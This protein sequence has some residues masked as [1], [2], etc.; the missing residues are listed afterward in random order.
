MKAGPF[1]DESCENEKKGKK[2]KKGRKKKET[3]MKMSAN[4]W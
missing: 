3:T 2:G 4:T 1:R